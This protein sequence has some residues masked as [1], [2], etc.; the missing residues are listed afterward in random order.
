MN[1]ILKYIAFA[2]GGLI[3]LALIVAGIVAATFNPNDYKP[4]IVKLVQDKKQRTLNIEGD[5]KLAFWPSMGANL[6]KISLSEHKSDK[7]FASVEGLKVSLALLPLLKKELI[8]DTI[9]VDGARANIVRYEDGTTNLDDLLSKDDTESEQ[10]KFDIDGVIVTN[11]AVNF[12]DRQAGSEYA[13]SKFNLKTGRVALAQPFDLET[14]FDLVASKPELKISADIQGNFMADPEAKHF[15]VKAL[16]ASI[17]GDLAG[18]KDVTVKLAGDIDARPE[19]TEL[20]VDGLKLAVTGNFSGAKLSADL[21][22]PKLT[23]LKDEVSGKEAKLSLTH[24]KGSDTFKA[25]LVLADVKGSPKAI[26]S[27]GI[28]GDISAKQGARTMQGKF[29]SPFSGNI[30]QMIFELHKLAGNL[31]VK[32]PA[33]PKGAMQGTFA[34]KLYADAKQEQVRSDFNL[35]IDNTRLNGDVAVTGFSKPDIKFN[36]NADTLDLNKLLGKPDSSQ[37]KSAESAGKAADLSA[38]KHLLLDGR[39]SIG[40]V[41]YDKYKVSNLA[42]V[43][44]ADGQKLSVNPLS[45]KLDDSQIKGSFAI[46][47]FAR[48]LYTFDIDIDKIDADRYISDSGSAKGAGKAAD[49]KPLDLS[50]LKALNANGSLRIGSLKYGKIQSSNIRIDLRADGEKLTLSP[51]AAKVDDSQ[52]QASIGITRFANP[53]FNFDVNIDKLDAD[54]YITSSENAQVTATAKPA[55]E[56][57]LDLSALKKF[58]ASG[59]ANIG[60]LK[61]ANVKTSNVKLRLNADNG[62]VDLAPFS[63]NLYEGSMAGSL[64]VDARNVPAIAFKQDMKNITIGPLLV[65]AINNNML[66]GKGNLSVDVTTQGATVGALK[67][68]LNGKAATN[69]AD[70]SVKGIDIAGTLRGYQNKLNT[71]KGEANVE[72]DMN[73]KTDFSEMSATFNIKNGVARN[74]DLNMKAP[75]FRITGS[76]DIDIGNEKINYLAKPTVVSTLKGQGGAG[77]EELSGVTIPVKLTGTFSK[78]SYALDF[79][80]IATALAQKKVLEKVGGSKG[81]AVQ[82]LIGSDTAGGLES[83]ISGSKSKTTPAPAESEPAAAQEAA[84]APAPAPAEEKPQTVEEKAKQKLNKLL[85]L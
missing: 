76:G 67:K 38:L 9:Y 77:L 41:L 51:L 14:D 35:A 64:K 56:T 40:S 44:K 39:V 7:E 16:D 24:E 58:N 25:N 70:G 74:D 28:S 72:A 8:V 32:D 30:E 2:L 49:D 57:P 82:K 34:L 62:V 20:L 83:L 19:N 54:R 81:E 65:D 46:S 37:T 3:V 18:G 5:I 10:I 42:L 11:S 43:I 22:A 61:L 73:K 21:A 80:G 69:L 4:L 1:K 85:G 13:L 75:L 71:L 50:A 59:D 47:Q 78:P 68:G 60:W 33:L 31:D 53:V 84:P 45:L 66:N 52:I 15:V 12:T 48:P 6:G 26:Q 17:K 63:A 55:A 79:A 29:S 27:S 23:V 36:L